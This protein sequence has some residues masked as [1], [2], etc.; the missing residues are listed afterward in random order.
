MK[1]MFDMYITHIVTATVSLHE[2]PIIKQV[3]Y[4]IQKTYFD[5]LSFIFE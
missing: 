3:S 4:N 5:D 2:K 1:F